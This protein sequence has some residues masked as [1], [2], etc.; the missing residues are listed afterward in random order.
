MIFLGRRRDIWFRCHI[1]RLILRSRRRRRL[2][3]CAAADR[4]RVYPE[5]GTIELRKSA[6]ADLR[7]F[8]TR[9]GVYHRAALRADPLATLLSMRRYFCVCVPRCSPALPAVRLSQPLH[10]RRRRCG[11]RE[12]RRLTHRFWGFR[13]LAGAV[14]QTGEK[15]GGLFGDQP[16]R[17][18]AANTRFRLQRNAQWPV[19]MPRLRTGGKV[20]TE[21]SSA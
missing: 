1:L 9:C 8:E 18:A 19:P 7:C 17:A 11:T 2:E 12:G 5:I 20:T 13:T 4:S 14:A 15:T 21:R 10:H 16:D 3:G 6:I